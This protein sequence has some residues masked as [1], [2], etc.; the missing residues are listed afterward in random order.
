MKQFYVHRSL[1]YVYTAAHLQQGCYKFY[2]TNWLCFECQ[3]WSNGPYV[4]GFVILHNFC[5]MTTTLS[6]SEMLYLYTK[7]TAGMHSFHCNVHTINV[8]QISLLVT[9][10]EISFIP[11]SYNIVHYMKRVTPNF[12][13]IFFTSSVKYW[14]MGGLP[15]CDTRA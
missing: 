12:Q 8:T 3:A 2:I 4:I 9:A 7:H 10:V 13:T 1:K 11:N 15:S 5:L 6:A 14:V